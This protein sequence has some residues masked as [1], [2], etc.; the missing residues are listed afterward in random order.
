MTKVLHLW[1]ERRLSDC[2]VINYLLFV[3]STTGTG[4]PDVIFV[5]LFFVMSK[6]FLLA[7]ADDGK[8]ALETG[9]M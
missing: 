4:R 1:S 7:A 8:T 2:D 3:P 9:E 6:M 5:Y